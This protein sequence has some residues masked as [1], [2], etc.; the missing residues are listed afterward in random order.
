[1]Q[2]IMHIQIHR[3][4]NS[5]TSVHNAT[6]YLHQHASR[7]YNN[8]TKVRKYAAQKY[9]SLN[10]IVPMITT[11]S[12]KESFTSITNTMPFGWKIRSVFAFT[13]TKATTSPQTR[14]HNR[15]R[16]TAPRPEKDFA[17]GKRAE[18]PPGEDLWQD[19]DTPQL[20]QSLHAND[21]ADGVWICCCGT[22]NE[23][24]HFLGAHPLK[25]LRCRVCKHIYCQKCGSSDIL[26]P[27]DPAVF[28]SY[29]R[30]DSKKCKRVGRVC[31]RCGLTHRAVS[32]D[33]GR[34]QF[35]L[36]CACGTSSSNDWITFYMG[37]PD[38]YRFDP[39]AAAVQLRHERTMRSVERRSQE[40][41]TLQPPQR[42]E[43]VRQP[44]VVTRRSPSDQ[45][46]RVHRD[47]ARPP[48]QHDSAVQRSVCE[49]LE[50][51]KDMA[52]RTYLVDGYWHVSPH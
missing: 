49:I 7:V 31:S 30:L 4:F 9:I 33:T 8:G 15:Q 18:A 39:N 43:L 10:N 3:V 6:I 38:K 48:L 34:V 36:V 19:H 35:D 44:R 14:Q 23:I 52:C 25:T 41:I 13:A 17:S 37:S 29:R 1:M 2:H 50:M 12:N 40:R 11:K 42:P 45:P 22:E 5:S 46:A 26:T 47:Q 32:P 24:V 20:M 21:I 28:P 27:F 16:R 51:R